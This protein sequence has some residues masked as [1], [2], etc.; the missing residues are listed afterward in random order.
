MLY[1]SINPRP[2]RGLIPDK[3]CRTFEVV[4]YLYGKRVNRDLDGG[5]LGFEDAPGLV[6]T[7]EQEAAA[8]ARIRLEFG[9]RIPF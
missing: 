6:E 3:S 4:L 1:A 8:L 7:L 9:L 5:W 2:T